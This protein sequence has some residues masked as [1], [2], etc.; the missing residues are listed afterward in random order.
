MDVSPGLVSSTAAGDTRGCGTRQVARTAGLQKRLGCDLGELQG[1]AGTAQTSVFT[2][3]P[4]D[5]TGSSPAG[6][7]A[8]SPEGTHEDL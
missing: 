8:L 1:K 3:R 4:S 7:P 5:D 2:L 6:L